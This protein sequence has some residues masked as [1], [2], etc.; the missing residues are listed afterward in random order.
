ML[1]S[2]AA[3]TIFPVKRGKGRFFKKKF[4]LLRSFG[5]YYFERKI[6]IYK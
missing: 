2:P 1:L 5:T 4:K 3:V 6:Y